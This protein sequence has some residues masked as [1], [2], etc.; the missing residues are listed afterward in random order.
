MFSRLSYIMRETWASLV[1]NVTLTL[2]S[3]LTVI[4]S[5]LLVG[6]A[7]LVR[8]AVENSLERWKDGVEFIVF[9][10]PEATQDQIDAVE[11]DLH[12]GRQVCGH[13]GP[14]NAH[15][16]DVAGRV[17]EVSVRIIDPARAVLE[18]AAPVPARSAWRVDHRVDED[19]EVL[20][21]ILGL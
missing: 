8:Y 2:A 4:V 13:R 17:G 5:L 21:K 15:D 7:L 20:P 19:V 11:R 3:L 12:F 14:R 18:T 9:M 10:N 16:L 1:R 6:G